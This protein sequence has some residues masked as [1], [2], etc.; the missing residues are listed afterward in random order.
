MVMVKNMPM[1]IFR[2]KDRNLMTKCEG[3]NNLVEVKDDS[4]RYK[5]TRAVICNAPHSKYRDCFEYRWLFVDRLRRTTQPEPNREEKPVPKT[6]P[7]QMKDILK[8]LQKVG[9]H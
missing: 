4:K 8:G 6:T 7:T 3:C 2:R 1:V 5:S 9:K